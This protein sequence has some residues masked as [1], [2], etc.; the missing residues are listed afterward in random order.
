[1]GKV[2][3]SPTHAWIIPKSGEKP[4]KIVFDPPEWQV[5]EQDDEKGL[6]FSRKLTEEELAELK[7]EFGMKPEDNK[8]GVYDADDVDLSNSNFLKFLKEE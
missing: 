6:L 1:M 8:I 5:E 3:I 7:T 2:F 4:I